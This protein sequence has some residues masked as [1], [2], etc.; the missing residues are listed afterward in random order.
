MLKRNLPYLLLYIL[1]I[2]SSCRDYK[3]QKE[4]KDFKAVSKSN[5]ESS[6]QVKNLNTLKPGIE[7]ISREKLALWSQKQLK[8]LNGPNWAKAIPIKKLSSGAIVFILE[9]GDEY[10]KVRTAIKV[11]GWVVK[12]FLLPLSKNTP[13]SSKYFGPK[14]YGYIRTFVDGFD[15]GSVKLWPSKTSRNMIVDRCYKGDKVVILNREDEYVK[16]RTINCKE[17]WCMK[18]FIK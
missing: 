9:V 1:I 5:T 3:N 2:L 7:A 11:E 6:Y 10:A 16:I 13:D 14:K 4:S 18:G 12:N 17:G 8:L 15:I